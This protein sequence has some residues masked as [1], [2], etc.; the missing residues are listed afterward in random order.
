MKIIKNNKPDLDI[1]TFQIDKPLNK[2][3]NNY[4]LFKHLNKSNF[5]IFLSK[6]GGG[7][8]SSIISFLKSKKLYKKTAYHQIF[9]FMPS[10]S[11]N[12]IKDNF[13]DKMLPE[14]QVFEELD[15][16]GLE[17]VKSI[18][19]GNAQEG[20]N[21]LLIFDDLQKSFKKKEVEELLLSIINNRRHLRISI[22][23]AIQNFKSLSVK[24]R[25]GITNL[26]IFKISKTELEYIFEE[27]FE[28]NKKKF[29]GVINLFNKE[30]E[31]NSHSFLFIDIFHQKLFINYDE[32]VL[33]E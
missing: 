12:S 18:A 15:L 20:F 27:V 7:K 22:W 8:T 1:P 28:E 16:E 17:Y 5:T 4:E 10:N 14:D 25:S 9:V 29:L 11:R 26:F 23:M 3:L 19:E 13:F 32:I 2:E 21:T 6:A 24:M 31:L 33:D 30:R